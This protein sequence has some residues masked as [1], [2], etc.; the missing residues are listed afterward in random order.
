MSALHLFTRKGPEGPATALQNAAYVMG[1]EDFIFGRGCVAHQLHL[2]ADRLAYRCGWE[3][4]RLDA[5]DMRRAV[6]GYGNH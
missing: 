6:R 1:R 5:E 3:V 2:A 4:E